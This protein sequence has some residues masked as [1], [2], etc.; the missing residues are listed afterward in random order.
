MKRIFIFIAIAVIMS[1]CSEHQKPTVWYKDI[2]TEYSAEGN[3]NAFDYTEIKERLPDIEPEKRQEILAL[4]D[5]KINSMTT[6]E[7]LI[8]CLDYPLF[9]DL[10]F[11]NDL[12]AGFRNVSERYNGLQALLKRNDVGEVITAF[13][14]QVEIEKVLTTDEYGVLRLEYLELMMSTDSVLN[15]ADKKVRRELFR[16]CAEN[17]NTIIEEYSQA[18]STLSLVRIACKILYLDNDEFREFADSDSAVT[19]FLGGSG[20]GGISEQSRKEI[21]RLAKQYM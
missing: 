15:S 19:D 11:Y 5:D 21:T 17:C 10:F 4:S 8:T 2:V 18:L 7:L 1:G 9:G 14:G 13:Y 6:E 12:T 16:I 20:A 3:G